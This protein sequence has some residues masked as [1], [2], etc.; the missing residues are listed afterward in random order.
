MDV[1]AAVALAFFFN[2]TDS[3]G[4]NLRGRLQVS[5]TTRLQVDAFNLE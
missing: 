4:A 5:T 3:N 1:D 2:F